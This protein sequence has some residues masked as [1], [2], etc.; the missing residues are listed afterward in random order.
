MDGIATSVTHDGEALKSAGLNAVISGHFGPKA[1][2]ALRAL[3]IEAWV[4]PPGI[5][6]EQALR[7]F[8]NDDL[9]PVKSKDDQ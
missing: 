2:D 9:E 6:A 5:T 4:A 8:S 7:M 1:C 3:A